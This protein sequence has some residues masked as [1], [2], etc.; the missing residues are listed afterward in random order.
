MM[1]P[2]NMPSA[3][4]KQIVVNLPAPWTGPLVGADLMQM[5]VPPEDSSIETDPWTADIHL[6]GT[7]TTLSVRRLED[8]DCSPCCE[9]SLTV[10]TGRELIYDD[11]EGAGGFSDPIDSII[12]SLTLALEWRPDGEEYGLSNELRGY[13]G[14]SIRSLRRS[15]P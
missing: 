6:E 1:N 8:D 15:K 4:K 5:P 14:D 7:Q 13:L 3:P 12:E 9:V 10:L 2:S 11:S